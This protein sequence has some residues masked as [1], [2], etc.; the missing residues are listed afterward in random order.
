MCVC[1]PGGGRRS[2]RTPLR[3]VPSPTAGTCS[4][5]S[6]A[7]RTALGA[8]AFL[9]RNICE[10][11]LRH[12]CFSPPYPQERCSDHVGRRVPGCRGSCSLR[13]A[14]DAHQIGKNEFQTFTLSVGRLPAAGTTVTLPAAQGYTDGTTVNWADTAAADHHSS[15]ASSA[16]APQAEKPHPA[17][18]FVTTPAGTRDPEPGDAPVASQAS[19]VAPAP[20]SVST[21]GDTAGWTGLVAGLIGLA[22][23][24]TALARSRPARSN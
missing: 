3:A 5:A 12:D 13:T 19:A 24:V 22:A 21:G 10:R 17:P 14:D 4:G 18:S 8:F 16:A 11:H 9:T 23:G 1:Q 15:A 6:P 2:P 7:P 20:E